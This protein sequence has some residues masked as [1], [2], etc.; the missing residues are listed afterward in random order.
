M[1]QQAYQSG[2]SI[3]TVLHKVVHDIEK[4]FAQKHPCLGNFLNFEGLFDNVS[5]D[6][7]LKTARNHGLHGLTFKFTICLQSG[8]S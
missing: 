5:F 8:I 6:A 1:N 7:I 4:I 3:V 2:K